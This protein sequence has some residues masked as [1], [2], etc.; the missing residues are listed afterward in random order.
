MHNNEIQDIVHL[1]R[2]AAAWGVGFHFA[3]KIGMVRFELP[4]RAASRIRDEFENELL[5]VM[6]VID[7]KRTEDKLVYWVSLEKNKSETI[8]SQ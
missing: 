3:S 2:F 5:N 7:F 8:K 1:K 6:G 4:F